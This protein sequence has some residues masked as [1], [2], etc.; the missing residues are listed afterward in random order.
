MAKWV[1]TAFVL[2]LIG[3]F[4]HSSRFADPFFTRPYEARF[5]VPVLLVFPEH[6][7]V[8]LVK[9]LSEVAPLS[10]EARYTFAIPPARQQWVERQI[11]TL[12]PPRPGS[13]WTLR[14]LQLAMTHSALTWRRI[15]TASQGRSTRRT[16]SNC[17][18]SVQIGRPGSSVSRDFDRC[19]AQR[20]PRTTHLGSVT[21][22][23]IA[24]WRCLG[25]ESLVGF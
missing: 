16:K 8:R 5:E 24:P 4:P 9:S 11:Q 14:V 2:S 21:L 17:S 19:C 13:I 20:C 6:V 18:D 1:I 23:S 3:L 15:A 7:E 25:N 22:H 10:S 12:P